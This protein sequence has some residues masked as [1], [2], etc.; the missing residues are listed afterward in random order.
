MA[1][2]VKIEKRTEDFIRELRRLKEQKIVKSY[3]DLGEISMSALEM[4]LKTKSDF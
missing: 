4:E 2:T 1:Q 3:K